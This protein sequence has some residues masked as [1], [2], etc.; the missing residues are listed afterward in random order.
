MNGFSVV[1]VDL[2]RSSFK[3]HYNSVFCFKDL[4][5]L[6]DNCNEPNPRENTR[7]KKCNKQLPGTVIYPYSNL[8]EKKGDW[9]VNTL[10]KYKK[11]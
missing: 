8:K 2:I 6:C 9:L 4:I 7:C 11:N 10:R 3:Y 5:K 1:L